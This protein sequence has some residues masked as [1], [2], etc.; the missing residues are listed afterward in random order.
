[1]TM[2]LDLRTAYAPDQPRDDHG[3]WTGDGVSSA[4]GSGFEGF[5]AQ[6]LVN[7]SKS[8]RTS[9][10]VSDTSSSPDKQKLKMEGDAL[11]ERTRVNTEAALEKVW[12]A[13]DQNFTA[14]QAQSFIEGLGRTVNDGLAHGSLYRTHETKFQRQTQVKDVRRE[15]REFAAEYA[16]RLDDPDPVATAAWVEYEF[17]GR[18]HPLADGVGRTTKMLSAMV[19]ARHGHP[20]PKYQDRKSYYEHI[21]KPL[22]DFTQYYRG[23]FGQR[24]AYSPD[25]PRDETGKW[26]DAGGGS[27]GSESDS[28]R[29]GIVPGDREKFVKLKA[30]WARVN[31]DLLRHVNRPDSPEARQKME[32]LKGIVKEMHTLRADPGGLEGIGLPG[33][34][35]DV[36]IVGAGPGGL[37]AAVMGGTDGL[38]TLFVDANQQVGGQ[39][40]FSSRVENYPGFPI[41]V[42]G[43]QLAERM[44][45]QA[46]RV[47]AEGKLGV[48][49]VGL[50]YDEKT[51]LKTVTLDNGETIEA[52]SVVLAGGV[53]FRKVDFPGSESPDVI[54]GDGKMLAQ[55]S[56]GGAAVVLGGSNGAAQAALGCAQD[57]EK[58]TVI[59]RSAITKSMSDYQVEALRNHPKI[60]LLEGDEIQQLLTD[61]EGHAVAAITKSGKQVDCDALGVFFGG[62]PNTKW[63]PKEI[64][65][66]GGHVAVNGD[67]ETKMPGVFAV[68]DTREGGIGRI[69]AAVGDGQMA[70]RNVWQYFSKLQK[71]RESTPRAAA[72]KERRPD[73]DATWNRLVDDLFELDY[74]NPFLS[75]MAEEPSVGLEQRSAYSPDQPR[76]ESGKWTDAGGGGSATDDAHVQSTKEAL[77]DDTVVA[78]A[79]HA[80]FSESEVRAEADK[81]RESATVEAERRHAMA[82][83]VGNLSARRELADGDSKKAHTD[84]YGRY[85]PERLKVHEQVIEKLLEKHL[86]E[87][88][89]LPESGLEHPTV[90]FLAGLPGAGKSTAVAGMDRSNALT[91]DPDA[92]K[93]LMPE[94]QGFNAGELARESGDIGD[95]LMQFAFKN[96]MNIVVDGTAKTSGAPNEKANLGDG[97]LGKIAAFHDAGYKTDVRFV[98]V[99]I[100]QSITRAVDRY[101]EN[102]KKYVA[103]GFDTAKAPRWV[104][105]DFIKKTMAD[106]KYGNKSRRSFELAKQY[107]PL[108]SYTHVNGWTGKVVD[109]K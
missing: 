105:L 21:N 42:T 96:R 85:T 29:G 56:G 28:K 43:E 25:Q 107:A 54:Y 66:K 76:D 65:I 37:A 1:M 102:M 35:R 78:V 67:L 30:Q 93:E 99:T 7:L 51:G 92:I 101:V 27:G 90:T 62:G 20:L 52:R 87:H 34:P 98:D 19:L 73:E 57:A 97:L 15:T 2:T 17:D 77:P 26:T 75:S 60:T 32:Q 108:D 41:G 38:D 84:A 58:V 55:K 8:S 103:A 74:A 86:A 82:V 40:K 4:D 106:E 11:A 95:A 71:Q 50:S 94:W 14:A 10:G 59:S 83:A 39:A 23:L 9:S 33:G 13:K 64:E 69:G 63:L 44:Y 61:S 49:A 80:G 31:D 53:E 89:K 91:A 18:I 5:K 24:S 45:D 104:E 36:L 68:G 72:A 81:V 16:K 48:R 6:A 47:G 70:L 100:N 79:K 88:G 109:K 22:A 3:R 46:Q 12:A